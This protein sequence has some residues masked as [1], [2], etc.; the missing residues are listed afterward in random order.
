MI[1][2]FQENKLVYGMLYSLKSFVSRLSPATSDTFHSYETN[3][4]KL[5]MFETPTGIKFV[6]N[7]SLEWGP[8][9]IQDMLHALYKEVVYSH[10][11]ISGYFVT[12]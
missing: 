12:M 5:S 8:G 9:V 6:L 3:K 10:Q 7:T 4:Y 11:F 2:T 1:I